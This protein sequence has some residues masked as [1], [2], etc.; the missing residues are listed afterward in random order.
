VRRLLLIILVCLCFSTPAHAQDALSPNA[1]PDQEGI[2][3]GIGFAPDPLPLAGVLAG[4]NID[5]GT[6]NMGADCRGYVTAQPDFRI[7]I[8]YPFSFLR[9]MFVSDSLLNDT[10]LIIRSPGGTYTCNDDSF[11]VDNP[12]LDFRDMLMG[13]YTIWV[14]AIAP[15]ATPQ[16]T[17]YL[18]ISEA[19]YPSSTGLVMPFNAPVVTPTPGGV[20][21]PTR[22]PDSFLDETAP[23]IHGIA[24]LEH[25]FLPDPYW[26]VI[27]GGGALPVPPLDAVD[28]S[29]TA[30]AECAGYASG[31]PQMQL[32]WRGLSTRLRLFFL[33]ANPATTDTALAVLA[34]EGWRCNRSFAGGFIDPLVEFINPPEGDYTVWVTNETAPD[35]FVSG[36]LYVTEKLYYP[37]FVPAVANPS[38]ELIAGLDSTAPPTQASLDAG[39]TLP[40]DPIVVNLNAGGGVDVRAANPLLE[41]RL[42]CAGYMAAAPDFTLNL[43]AAQAFLRLFFLPSNLEGDA[44]LIVRAADGRWYCNDDSYNSKHPTVNLIGLST[45]TYQVWAG[46]FDAADALPGALYVTGDDLTPLDVLGE[47]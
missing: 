45:G 44:T 15:N 14:G 26:A 6:L 12:S 39:E 3:L 16:G 32:E 9:L 23:P 19:I 47:S 5:T 28:P 46:N 36:I 37:T 4:G 35:E 22:A 25:G 8:V 30:S 7:N 21:L 42:G 31:A 43:S 40:S 10:S 33:P 34:P 17:L 11:T 29:D 38:I 1:P 27:V 41:G 13:E 2:A 18:T 20:A 24:M